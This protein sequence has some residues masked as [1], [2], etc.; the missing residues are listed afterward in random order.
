MCMSNN[1]VVVL[2]EVYNTVVIYIL[3]TFV[4]CVQAFASVTEVW[5]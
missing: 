2:S 5:K 1:C 3:F 4:V